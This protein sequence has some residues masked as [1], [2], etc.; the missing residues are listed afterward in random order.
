MM[1]KSRKSDDCFV[2]YFQFDEFCLL[3]FLFKNQKGVWV[4]HCATD[5]SRW[6]CWLRRAGYSQT[7]RWRWGRK[8]CACHAGAGWRSRE[9]MRWDPKADQTCRLSVRLPYRLGGGW[10]A[11]VHPGRGGRLHSRTGGETC[12]CEDVGFG[13]KLIFKLSYSVCHTYQI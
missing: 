7:L 8:P 5:R 12:S 9:Q 6:R 11:A 13:G 3:L 1:H 2:T 10:G 4:C